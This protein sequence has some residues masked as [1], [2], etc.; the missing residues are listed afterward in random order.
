M[1]HGQYLKNG[2]ERHLP[3]NLGVVLQIKD[4]HKDLE[5]QYLACKEEWEELIWS[6]GKSNIKA[7]EGE[8]LHKARMLLLLL[9]DDF[10][11]G[12][13][14]IIKLS[15]NKKINV[16]QMQAIESYLNRWLIDGS[17]FIQANYALIDKNNSLV[18]ANLTGY[19]E[20]KNAVTKID[21]FDETRPKSSKLI[22]SID[23][24]HN[25]DILQKAFTELV[26]HEKKIYNSRLE[27]ERSKLFRPGERDLEY[28]FY[29]FIG[30][31][32][33]EISLIVHKKN[34]SVIS[35]NIG[36]R[37]KS[38][39]HFLYGTLS[40]GTKKRI[41]SKREDPNTLDLY[42]DFSI[43]ELYSSL[44]QKAKKAKKK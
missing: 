30:K 6:S 20:G 4:L 34:D 28:I 21:K 19:L 32:F 17:H 18:Q 31:K 25:I 5:K 10:R 7:K 42:L 37:I 33:S 43:D 40:E 12:L 38:I 41:L 14:E 16:T 24:S 3:T 39:K 27:F 22:L 13:I 15:N 26:Q 36:K 29:Y 11:L 2:I 8:L 23:L 35:T 44:P 9:V 1:T